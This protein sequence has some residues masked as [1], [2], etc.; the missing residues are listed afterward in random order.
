MEEKIKLGKAM[1]SQTVP[2]FLL[3]G[4]PLLPINYPS[5]RAIPG[6]YD[7]T[8]NLGKYHDLVKSSRWFYKF[9][10]IA[11]TVLN[12]MA[13]M[14][15]TTI[16]NRKK[17]K[18]NADA[19]DEQVQAYFDA[20]VKELR[21]IIKQMAV[22]YLLH[23][24]VVPAYSFKRV[25]GDLISEKLGRTRYSVPDQMWIR[26]PENLELKRKP[27]GIDRQ[28]W[29]KIPKADIEL[30]QNKGVRAD[31]SEDKDA[32]QYLV[33]NFP[34]Y[35]KAIRKGQTKF[36]LEDARAIMRKPNSFEDY[37]TPFLVNA[38]SALQ[39][40]AYL[41]TMDKSIAARAIEAIRHI[42]V[43]DKDFPA[44]TDDI[45]AVRLE[46]Q[47]NSS[48]GERIFNLFTNHTV[49]I[50]WVFPPLDALL[51]EAKY[52]E[53]NADIF[54]AM[55]FPRI[56]TTGETL[57]SNSSDS[58]IASLGPKAT[59]E[60][61]RETIIKWLTELYKELAEKNNFKRI[62]E[63]YFAPIAT[64]DYTALVQF[65]VDAMNAGAISKDTIAQLYGS[66]FE[67]EAGQI[68]TEQDSGVL[69]PAEL[70][71]QKDQEFQMK[72]TEKGQ[73]F[74]RE[75]TD[76]AHKNNLETIKAQP[77]PAPKKAAEALT[78]NEEN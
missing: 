64:S 16:R 49:I 27:M 47:A 18:L 74:T 52:A 9:D 34:D 63:P 55:G 71:T 36:L 33:E 41:K 60:D 69:S 62:P 14:A 23:G 22:E 1:A 12:R 75:Q 53:P 58:K 50:E 46:I 31:G 72:T 29:L 8:A 54:L 11:G 44:D 2:N 40:K 76:T 24:L 57:R 42:R 77:K 43:G 51:N 26:N 39:H 6:Y 13:D 5:K 38:L 3:T 67:T 32:Y 28:I 4:D 68:Q 48:T 30:V 78:N 73:E 10:P 25:R 19:V 45:D 37:P 66:D 56:L 65:A 7:G 70:Q 61:L 15:V 59:L 20:L 17:T 35:V 21:P